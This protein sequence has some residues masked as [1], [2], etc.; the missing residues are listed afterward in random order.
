MIFVAFLFYYF[1][2]SQITN[3]KLIMVFASDTRYREEEMVEN[4]VMKKQEMDSYRER[5]RYLERK[6]EREYRDREVEYLRKERQLRQSPVHHPHPSARA[7][8]PPED[9]GVLFINFLLHFIVLLHLIFITF[10]IL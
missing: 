2:P 1:I 7:D 5:E 3:F 10:Y 9:K 6:E 8:Y 4:N